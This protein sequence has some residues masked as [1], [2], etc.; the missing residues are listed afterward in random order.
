FQRGG[1]DLVAAVG[2]GSAMDVAKCIRLY[3]RL[4]PDRSFDEQEP[5]PNPSE[6]LAVPTTA[7]SGSEATRF[8]VIYREG[9]KLSVADDRCLPTAVLLD[10]AV[11]RPLPELQRKCTMLDALC[12]GLESFWSVNACPESRALSAQ[13]IRLLLAH[14]DA[15]LRREDGGDA[16]MQRAAYLA[17]QAINLTQTTAGHAMAYGLTTRYGL[18]HG[19]AA[20]MCVARLWPFMVYYPE[21]CA[22]PGGAAGLKRT[23][24]ELAEAMGCESARDAVRRFQELLDRLDL[25]R[26]GAVEEDIPGLV[27][28]VN[29]QRLKNNPVAL[30]PEAIGRLYREI[31][32]NT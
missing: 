12:H 5:I 8:A 3:G 21:P 24:R 19:Q 18:P 29:A 15:Y 9:V 2:G 13:A 23:F 7:G 10:P 4:D 27:R 6:L 11:L 25:P 20:A 31:L 26:P 14:V 30:S 17:G 28:G 32:L 16:A 22:A 1:C